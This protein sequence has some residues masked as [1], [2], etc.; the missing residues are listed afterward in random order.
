MAELDT[1][2]RTLLVQKEFFDKNPSAGRMA[3]PADKTF[4]VAVKFTGNLA[5][6][7]NAGLTVGEVACGFAFGAISG[8][9][10]SAG[11]ASA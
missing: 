7:Q 1:E 2:L 6:L 10:M 8:T 4:F 11:H 3:M 5:E 9:R